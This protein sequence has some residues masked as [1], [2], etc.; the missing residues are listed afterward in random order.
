MAK[1]YWIARIDVSDPEPFKAYAAGAT[2]AVNKYGGRYLARGGAYQGLEGETRARNVV[3]EFP[4]MQA[5]IDCW[6]SP[7]YQAAKKHRDGNCDAQ[8]VVVEGIAP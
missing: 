5:A 8:F 1:G 6:N 4:S 7:E 3:I 2:E